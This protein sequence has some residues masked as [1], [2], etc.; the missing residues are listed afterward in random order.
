M[1]TGLMV[2]A[3]TDC[4]VRVEF[5]K[6][7]QVFIVKPETYEDEEDGKLHY[8]PTFLPLEFRTASLISGEADVVGLV[9]GPHGRTNVEGAIALHIHKKS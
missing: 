3:Y 2:T 5:A 4:E 6:N 8:Q 9:R 7:S 1:Y